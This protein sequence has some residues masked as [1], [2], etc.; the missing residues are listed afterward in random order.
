[1]AFGRNP[2]VA[3]TMAGLVIFMCIMTSV[4]LTKTGSLSSAFGLAC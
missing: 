4:A 1:L 3:D 2:A